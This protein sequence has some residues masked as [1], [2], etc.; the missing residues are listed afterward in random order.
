MPATTFAPGFNGAGFPLNTTTGYA[1][2][3]VHSAM[4]DAVVGAAAGAAVSVNRARVAHSTNEQAKDGGLVPIE[5]ISEINRNSTAQDLANYEAELKP[6]NAGSFTLPRD[7][8]GNG[9]PA[10]TRSVS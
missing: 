3:Q 8:S 2:R 1:S 7:L 4:A 6:K 10:F 9:G 5:T